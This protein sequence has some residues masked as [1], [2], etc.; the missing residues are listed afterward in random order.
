MFVCCQTINLSHLSCVLR[1]FSVL[2][3]FDLNTF[4]SNLTLS[5]FDKCRKSDLFETTAHYDFLVSVSLA[6]AELRA[7]P[8]DGLISK[9]VFSLPASLGSSSQL[10]TGVTAVVSWGRDSSDPQVSEMT[11]MRRLPDGTP[12]VQSGE[13]AKKPLT[14]PKFV[15]LSVES[16]PGS[17][18]DAW[19][20]A[21]LACLQLKKED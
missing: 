4:V 15:P 12:V 18:L 11:E 17:E 7:I 6:N 20:K 19:L 3:V 5:Q 8:L 21:R 9:G 10:S 1:F 13:T 14:L 16:S 2:A